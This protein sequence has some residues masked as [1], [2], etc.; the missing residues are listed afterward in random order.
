MLLLV[1]VTARSATA[2]IA[3]DGKLISRASY[4]VVFGLHEQDKRMNAWAGA[5]AAAAGYNLAS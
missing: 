3:D 4:T 2:L 1:T 5:Y